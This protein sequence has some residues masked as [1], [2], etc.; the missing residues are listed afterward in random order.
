MA[1][2]PQERAFLVLLVTSAVAL[3]LVLS[4][5]LYVFILAAVLASVLWP[6]HQ[7]LTDGLRGRRWASSLV[8]MAG[9][10]VVVVAPTIWLAGYLVNEGARGLEGILWELSDSDG[11]WLRGL[12]YGYELAQ[13]DQLSGMLPPVDEVHD[14]VIE[15]IRSTV[16]QVTRAAPAGVSGLLSALWRL[17]V[18]LVAFAVCLYVAFTRG[19]ELLDGLR[20]V[21][22]LRDQYV[23]RLFQ[24]FQ[25]LAM[26]IVVGMIG[27]GIAQGFIAAVGFALA[28]VPAAGVLGAAT[29]VTSMVPVIGSLLVWGP[30]AG[31][32]VASGRT[33]A[34]AFVTVWSLAA[35]ASADNVVK[36]F[37]LKNQLQVSPLWMMLALF[38]GLLTMGVRGLVFGPL[39]L[40]L[41]LTLY[42][43]Y[44]RDFLGEPGPDEGPVA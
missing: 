16:L 37:L 25:Q 44:L 31:G 41:Y 43:I 9:I 34:A 15:A 17:S 4:P 2:D 11:S 40:V 8:L 36:P 26:N 1:A 35:T 12:E 20:R 42:T 19:P 32:L 24:V 22:P 33:G 28:G 18:D 13:K 3:L 39:L 30:V 23:S 5:F 27:T 29:A 21:A 7:R 38:G 10:S 14:E 6:A